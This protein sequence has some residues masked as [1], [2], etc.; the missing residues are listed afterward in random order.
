MVTGPNRSICFLK[1]WTTLPSLPSVLP[2]LTDTKW[3]G[4]EVQVL[5]LE[6]LAKSQG[7]YQ[8]DLLCIRLFAFLSD[9]DFFEAGLKT[10]E[11]NLVRRVYL[12]G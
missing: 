6:P 1:R 2:N 10:A 3:V 7:C 4:F 12:K 11:G 8:L 5:E 9:R